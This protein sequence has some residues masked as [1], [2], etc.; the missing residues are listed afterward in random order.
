M[1]PGERTQIRPEKN[2]P[3]PEA[4]TLAAFAMLEWISGPGRGREGPPGGGRK[5]EHWRT[6]K[7]AAR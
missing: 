4:K 3:R 1:K 5:T 6:E 7:K 2:F